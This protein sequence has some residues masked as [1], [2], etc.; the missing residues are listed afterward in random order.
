MSF[1]P[2]KAKVLSLLC[3]TLLWLGVGSTAVYANE[4]TGELKIW[5]RVTVTFD[6]LQ[7]NET[8]GTNPFTNYRLLVTFT[9]SQSGASYLVPG[10]YAAD[11]NAGETGAVNGNKWRVHFTPDREGTW[12]YTAS[13]RTGSYIAIDLDPLAGTPTS[14]NGQFGSFDIGPTDKTGIDHRGKGMLRYVGEH[15]FQFAGNG[16][17]YLKVA[18]DSPENLLAFADFDGTYDTACNGDPIDNTI[19][20]YPLHVADWQAGDPT[21][22]GGK[23]KGLIGALNYLSSVGLSSTYFI[24]YN[25][26][27]GDG[28]DVWP[29]TNENERER[30]DVSKLDQ[31]EIV[32]SHMDVK[33][34]QL[35]LVLTERENAKALGTPGDELNDV[36]KLYYREL[37]A[38][39][40]HHLA[41][42][43]NVG[44][45]NPNGDNKKI[46]FANYIRSLDPYEHPIAV[47]TSDSK[48]YTFYEFL[49][50]EPSFEAT[51]LQANIAE[52]NDLAI[53]YRTESTA[54][55]KK[56]AVYADE[57]SP[58]AG[59]IR[60][61]EL[62]QQGLWG[63]LMGGG[64][65]VEWFTTDDLDLEDFRFYDLLWEEMGYA[66][67]F[68]QTYL[69]FERMEPANELTALEGDY[70]LAEE[71]QV[72]AVYLPAGGSV[73]LDIGGNSNDNF[74]ISWY[75][76]R[77]GGS[78]VS[79]ST[80]S[81]S[82]GGVRDLGTPP[83][84]QNLDWAVLVEKNGGSGGG[85]PEL[86]AS[87]L[88]ESVEEGAGTAANARIKIER[89]GDTTAPLTFTISLSGT[90]IEGVDFTDIDKQQT[91]EAG[92]SAKNIIID[93]IDDLDV[94]GD[95]TVEVTLETSAAYTIADGQSFA[96]ATILDD[97]NEPTITLGDTS[98][99][100]FVSALDASLVLQHAVGEI[101]LEGPAASA[102]DVSGD[103]S[104]SAFDAS[105][106]LQFLVGLIDC[107]PA[108][109][110]CQ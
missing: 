2:A 55:G 95:E 90:A 27:E 99:N 76:P 44:E 67:H 64:A 97:D 43:W 77:A 7:T 10:F 100:G 9:H 29:W 14:F 3:Y 45:E 82:G 50:G 42:Q 98:Q 26:D 102:G 37:I 23:G 89:T 83:S 104:T 72:Y 78:L 108:D 21:W 56:W 107:F 74:D 35:H 96:S 41:I 70:V 71:G 84:G 38:R 12:M 15:Y 79:G 81:V 19:H 60:A 85:L 68:F 5:H 91:I 20:Q 17:Y 109:S 22:Q 87:V 105:L 33:G 62:R 6:G 24:T 8:A 66:R 30:F 31:W 69:P 110:S 94:E 53:Y 58:N 59:N 106:I 86:S 54:A 88:V 57:Q 32:F 63:N 52:F 101:A 51:S 80:G 61:D 75:N 46:E 40:G 49:L 28:C 92:S 73:S 36:R 48:A 1:R 39:F 16:E 65:G 103:G 4:V 25:L 13:F 34:I 47:H 93:P 11:G 18:P